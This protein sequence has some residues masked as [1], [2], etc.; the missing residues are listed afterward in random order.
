[1]KERLRKETHSTPPLPCSAPSPG[2]GREEEGE[3]TEKSQEFPQ[4][5]SSEETGMVREKK[6]TAM[7]DD[8]KKKLSPAE[9]LKHPPATSTKR[10]RRSN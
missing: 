10:S 4:S 3:F 2:G 9:L 8:K 6:K 7:A 5:C 1:M